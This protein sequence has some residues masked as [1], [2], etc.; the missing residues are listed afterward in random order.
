MRAEAD[1]VYVHVD[2]P[3]HTPNMLQTTF[4]DWIPVTSALIPAPNGDY[5]YFVPSESTSCIRQLLVRLTCLARAYITDVV[6]PPG[7]CFIRFRRLYWSRP[8]LAAN[9][10]AAIPSS[11][12][13]RSSPPPGIPLACLRTPL[14]PPS[15]NR[16]FPLHRSQFTAFSVRIVLK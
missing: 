16:S 15:F 6:F 5:E 12:L 4:L 7:P 3:V 13:G 14:C 2:V 10:Y 11:Y 8:S 9:C 1:T